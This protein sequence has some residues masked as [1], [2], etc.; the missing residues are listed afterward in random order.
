MKKLNKMFF[1]LV[2]VFIIASLFVA[3]NENTT[4]DDLSDNQFTVT[5]HPN[6]GEKA[7]IW[8]ISDDIP[9]IEREGYYLDG[10]YLDSLFMSATSF[11][12]LKKTGFDGNLDV[13][14]KWVSHKHEFG[15]WYILVQ[16][17]HITEGLRVWYCSLCDAEKYE[18]MQKNRRPPIL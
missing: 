4:N 6:N 16:P 7:F 1:V 3:C 12:S 15:S 14:V 2:L 5:V 11:E 17:T 18:N 10:I 8:K 13:Y 9:T